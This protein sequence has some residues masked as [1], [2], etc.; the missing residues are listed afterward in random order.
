MNGIVSA[1]RPSELT[2]VRIAAAHHAI[3][4]QIAPPNSLASALRLPDGALLAAAYDSDL[5]RYDKLGLWRY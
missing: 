1:C 3:S 4:A 5:D 2:P